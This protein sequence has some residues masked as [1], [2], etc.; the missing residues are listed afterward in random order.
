MT[1]HPSSVP[2][3]AS[4]EALLV[5]IAT[6]LAD[7]VARGSTSELHAVRT[8]ARCAEQRPEALAPAVY[9]VVYDPLPTG[10][11]TKAAFEVARHHVAERRSPR[12]R[13]RCR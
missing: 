1:S 11:L 6:D 10:L 9:E 2:G 4:L 5:N 8:L 3:R 7:E 13:R 12:R